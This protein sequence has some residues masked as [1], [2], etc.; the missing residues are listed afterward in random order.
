[1]PRGFTSG[2][3]SWA[4]TPDAAN[5]TSGCA[6]RRTVLSSASSSAHRPTLCLATS[7]AW[8]AKG[9][10]PAAEVCPDV[11]SPPACKPGAHIST[12][13]WS[14]PPAHTTLQADNEWA[15]PAAGLTQAYHHGLA[16]GCKAAKS[17]AALLLEAVAPTTIAER[18]HLLQCALPLPDQIHQ[19]PPG[20]ALQ[21]KDVIDDDLARLVHR[22]LPHS[23]DTAWLELRDAISQR[24]TLHHITTVDRLREAVLSHG[25]GVIVTVLHPAPRQENMA[26]H[27][28]FAERLANLAL[29]APPPPPQPAVPRHQAALQARIAATADFTPDD[30]WPFP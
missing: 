11:D 21:P 14:H 3:K 13:G 24:L 20:A 19:W 25:V 18:A 8:R 22:A 27:Y 17:E 10:M 9:K 15:H 4:C 2:E 12:W 26:L 16:I 28:R 29:S 5:V 6:H 23:T 7:S 1:M 30:Y